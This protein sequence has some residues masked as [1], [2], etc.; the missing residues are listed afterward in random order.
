MANSGL[1]ACSQARRSAQPAFI[2]RV[3]PARGAKGGLLAGPVNS[4]PVSGEIKAQQPG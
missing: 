1:S 3:C 4:P 2:G